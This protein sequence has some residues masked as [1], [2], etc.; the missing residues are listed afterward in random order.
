MPQ[1][2]RLIVSFIGRQD[3]ES[4]GLRELRKAPVS[5]DDRSPILR[6]ILGLAPEGKCGPGTRLM[7]FDDDPAG[8]DL[9]ERFCSKLEEALPEFGLRGLAVERRRIALPSGPTDLNA[10][11][12]V[13]WAALGFADAQRPKEVIFH[14]SSGT[15][16]MQVTL[17]LA[18]LCLPFETARLFETSRERGVVTVEPPYVLALREKLR[19]RSG[20]PPRLPEAARKLL[21]PNTVLDDP[22]ANAAFAALHNAACARRPARVLIQGPTGSGKWHA[23]RQFAIWRKRPATEWLDDAPLAGGE[24]PV[25]KGAAVLVYRLDR[26][27]A[28]ALERLGLWCATHRDAAVVGTWRTDVPPKAPLPAV[29]RDGLKGA[30]HLH[31]PALGSRSDIVALAEALARQL[32]LWHAKIRERL[33][34]ELLTDVYPHNLHDLKSVL[35]T[36]ASLAGA[37][38]HPDRGVYRRA[39]ETL[40]ARDARALLQ[41]ACDTATAL[42]FSRER[43]VDDVLEA[44]K[45]AVARLAQAEGRTQKEIGQLLGCSQQAVSALLRRK[46]DARKWRDLPA[47]VDD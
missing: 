23:A 9:R 11:F 13:V 1:P 16:A 33:Q 28:R 29:A 6:L 2:E 5:S 4:F 20:R 37:R 8:S 45:V 24:P 47:A 30:A 18:A 46:L 36:A 7:L 27:D 43:T 10:L 42:R 44:I 3:V 17:L 39:M 35:A 34:Y 14:L 12:E 25:E 21:L 41:E 31:L 26:W 32:G 38:R 22:F 19:P 15:P 40:E